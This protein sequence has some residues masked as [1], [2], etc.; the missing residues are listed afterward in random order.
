[1]ASDIM[2][3][4]AHFV[5]V[6]RDQVPHIEIVREIIRKVRKITQVEALIDPTFI[7]AKDNYVAGVDGKKMSKTYGNVTPIKAPEYITTQQTNT[8]QTDPCKLRC[9]SP[10][11]PRKCIVWSYHHH[12]TP[13]PLSSYIFSNCLKGCITCEGCKRALTNN[14]LRLS[15]KN[16]PPYR[17]N[18]KEI[19]MRGTQ[20]AREQAIKTISILKRAL[21][22]N[23]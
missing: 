16:S 2:L 10:G 20:R 14:F 8:T 19:F 23:Q 9:H 11:N 12:L 7:V 6:G 21:G 18:T 22:L 4:N 5:L 3:Y 1:M 17:I 13:D 15:H